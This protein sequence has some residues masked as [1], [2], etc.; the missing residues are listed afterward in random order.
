MMMNLGQ[1]CDQ[2]YF[3]HP[4]LNWGETL[5]VSP[6]KDKRDEQSVAAQA[7]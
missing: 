1:Y 6:S 3:G 7:D 2:W 4:Y 5:H